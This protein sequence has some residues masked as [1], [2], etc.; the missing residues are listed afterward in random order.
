M[1]QSL[2][3]RPDFSTCYH[4][5]SDVRQQGRG[6]WNPHRL[7]SARVDAGRLRFQPCGLREPGERWPC[8]VDPHTM[9]RTSGLAALLQIQVQGRV[10]GGL[11]LLFLD[12]RLLDP[13]SPW[14]RGFQGD[15]GRTVSVSGHH[16]G[17]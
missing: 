5:F 7:A 1:R 14:T 2:P 12:F 8:N 6:E 4:C 15:L 11:T 17:T 10:S 13:L 3:H 16:R 9:P